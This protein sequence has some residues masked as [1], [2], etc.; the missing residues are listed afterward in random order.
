[1]TIVD[2]VNSNVRGAFQ[3]LF[4]KEP[5]NYLEG[6]SLY[7]II[8]QGRLNLASLEVLYNHAEDPELKDLI[9]ESIDSLVIPVIKG[10]E[11]FLE[12][13]SV[14][15]PQF[16]FAEHR[17]HDSIEI[18]V[19]AHLTDEEIAAVIGTMAK[20]SQIVLLGAL[21]QSYQLEIGLMH[22]KF[23]DVGLDWNYKLLQLMLQRGWLP[24]LAKMIH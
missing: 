21:H 5:V 13:S 14:E 3:T 16:S 17:L 8:A 7:G 18:P 9:K 1:M 10:C 19:D 15:S 11:S 22:R 23:L 6:A 20:A 24:H 12:R 4:D 2:K